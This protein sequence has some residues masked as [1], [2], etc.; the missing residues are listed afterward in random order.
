MGE[1]QR[2]H[3]PEIPDDLPELLASPGTNDDNLVTLR[4]QAQEIIDQILS[5]T[6]P[7]GERVRAKLRLCIFRH[8]GRPDQ[9]LL[10]HLLNRNN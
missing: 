2:D 6:D 7:G 9:A 1:P 3:F 10:E 8:P 4:E 5:G